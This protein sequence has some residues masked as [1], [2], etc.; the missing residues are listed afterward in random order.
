MLVVIVIT[1]GIKIIIIITVKYEVNFVC[2][3][4]IV[5][6]SYSNRII[7]NLKFENKSIILKRNQIILLVESKTI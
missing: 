1:N 6:K 3:L 4:W 7:T 2:L 5:E